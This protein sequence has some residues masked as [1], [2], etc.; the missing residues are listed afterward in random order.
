MIKLRRISLHKIK[1]TVSVIAIVICAACEVDMSIKIDGQNPPSFTLSGSGGL[2]SFGVTEVP[3]ENQTQTIQRRS[4]VNIPLWSILPT[5]K[6]NSIRRLPVITYG[7]LPPG[8]TQ[9]FPADGSPPTPLVEGKIY[10]AGGGAYGA[11]GRLIWLKVQ[12]GKTVEIP[13]PGSTAEGVND[14]PVRPQ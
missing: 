4:D 8:F 7:K 3:P 9:Q 6:D 1:W 11:N 5:M 12:D 13:I 10:E 14:K 2:I